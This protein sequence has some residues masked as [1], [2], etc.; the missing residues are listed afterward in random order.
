MWMILQEDDPDDY[1][2]AT[3]QNHSVREFVERAF[4]IVGLNYRDYAVTDSAF[5]RPAEVEM[6]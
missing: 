6:L 5:F 2:I 4:Q 1:V 3:A